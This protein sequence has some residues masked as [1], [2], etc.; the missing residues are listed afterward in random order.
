[1]NG[2]NV[3]RT[4]LENSGYLGRKGIEKNRPSVVALLKKAHNIFGGQFLVDRNDYADTSSPLQ[5]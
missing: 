5:K 3:Y 1:M 4:F 2:K